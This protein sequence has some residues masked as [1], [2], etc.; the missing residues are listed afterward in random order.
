MKINLKNL[1]ELFRV[2]K[3]GD[4]D[5]QFYESKGYRFIIK[6]GNIIDILSPRA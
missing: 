5:Q 4:K 1:L 2:G 3:L 6:D